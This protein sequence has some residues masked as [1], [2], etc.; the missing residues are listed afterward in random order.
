MSKMKVL[1][2]AYDNES[3]LT[4]FPLGV[5]YLAA[6]LRNKGCEVSIYPQ[7]VY[8]LPEEHLVNYLKNNHFDLV[9]VGVIGGYYQY[10]KL[11][12][13]SAAIQSIPD[14]G[15]LYVLGGHGPSP[16]PEFFLR[17]T[18]ADAVVMGEGEVVMSNLVN[19]L[20]AGDSLAKVKG[21]AYQD[22]DQVMINQR[23]ELIKDVDA[24]PWPA[25][26]LFR[27]DYYTMMRDPGI[28]PTERCH[29]VF[30]GRG[31]PFT[32]NFCYRMDPGFRPR[33]A[34]NV[35]EEMKILQRDYHVNFF[36][37]QDD[38]FMISEKRVLDFCEKL[39]RA[40]LGV[41]FI[42]NGRLNYATREVL[43]T[44][45]KAGCTFINYGIEALDDQVLE[46]MRKKLTVEQIIKGVENTIAEGLHPGLNVIWGNIGDNA[47]TL[48]KGVDF[49]IKYSTY[50]QLRSI[51][52]VTPYPGSPLYYYAIEKGLIEGPED[53]YERKHINSDL[54]TV[55]FT[56]HS[57]EECY[58]LLYEANKNLVND[59]IDHQK[60][61]YMAQLHK[62]YVE[63]DTSFR[64][65]RQT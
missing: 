40:N 7:D 42:C 62:L 33:S 1:F 32:C 13:I 19:A 52:P 3:F 14:R 12:K 21:I 55:N 18:G 17:Q 43:R 51:R 25:W 28:R 56:E 9:G 54:F 57:D 26:D 65:F 5:A 46:N 2:I 49:I 63:K 38:L 47:A 8:H 6:V 53:F 24:L 58:Q 59:Y 39:L 45:K 60:Q 23:E 35:I 15:F 61:S 64:G 44:M 48:R 31:C 30:T 11:L 4:S 29:M 10:R 50:A 20:E 34:E 27:M 41:R 22:G 16:E 36:E 37:F